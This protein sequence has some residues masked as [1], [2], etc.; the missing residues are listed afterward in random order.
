MHCG[1]ETRLDA[2]YDQLSRGAREP[3]GQLAKDLEDFAHQGDKLINREATTFHHIF[4]LKQ[5]KVWYIIHIGEAAPLESLSL[6]GE[7]CW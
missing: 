5:P 7:F 4:P 6:V 2:P 1:W 3:E